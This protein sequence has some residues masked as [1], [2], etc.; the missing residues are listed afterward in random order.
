MAE[1]LRI[2][3]VG[4]SAG[5]GHPFSFSAII[6]G[7]DENEGW[8]DW[9][10]ILAYLKARDPSEV[11]LDDA[12]VTHVYMPDPAMAEALSK[13]CRVPNIVSAPNEMIGEVDAVM[14]LRDD[15]ESHWPLAEPFL[16]AGLK[17]FVDKPMC[18]NREDLERFMPYVESGQMMSCSGLTFCG[19]LDSVRAGEIAFGE[20]K[21]V[22]AA[23]LNDWTK[24]GVHMM[25]AVQGA[26]GALPVA[27]QRHNMAH[28]SMAVRFDNGVTVLI[29]A[30][31]ALPKCFRIDFFG[32]E[33]IHAVDISD[34]FTAFRR[35]VLAFLQQARDGK[36]A[37]APAR[38]HRMMAT[39]IAGLEAQPGGPEVEIKD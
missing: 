23:V 17:V 5:N 24:Y 11:G 22:R 33:A 15:P 14:I 26:L 37:L 18:N 16:R 29:D 10:G 32:T 6:N 4:F 35:T 12:Q 27:I 1:P 25:E 8:D 2:G 31:G 34:N 3:V 13:A 28:E 39:L 9:A 30:M 20:L 7:F 19:E 21:L 36:P 38:T